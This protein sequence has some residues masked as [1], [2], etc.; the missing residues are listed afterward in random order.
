MPFCH[1]LAR[2]LRFSGS[3][4]QAA[5][6]KS[7]RDGLRP[8]AVPLR[9]YVFLTL[10]FAIFAS[11][12]EGALLLVIRFAFGQV[13]HASPYV[14]WMLP[15]SYMILF[16]VV[17]L[18]FAGIGWIVP[19]RISSIAVASSFGF[20]AAFGP[21]LVMQSQGFHILAIVLLSLGLAATVRRLARRRPPGGPAFSR[22]AVLG[23][24]ALVAII[25]LAQVGLRSI[26]GDSEPTGPARGEVP[27]VLLLVLDTVRAKS[28]GLYGHDEPTTPEIEAFAEKGVV[29]DRGVA[30][31]PW[32]LPSHGS[33][34]TG[35]YPNELS[36]DWD[37]PLDDTYPT[38]AGAMSSGGYATAGFVGNLA[39]VSR[40]FGLNRGFEHYDD[41][42]ISLGQLMVS[43]SAGR[44]IAAI[45][46][47]RELLGFHDLLNRRSAAD[48]NRALLDWLDRPSRR[49][50]F[51]FV[52]YFDA[53]EPYL[54]PPDLAR[55]FGARP[56]ERPV[57]QWITLF[58]GMHGEVRAGWELSEE[59]LANG[60]A[61]YEAA[62]AALD[63]EIGSLLRELER[64]GELD[65]TIVIITSDHGEQHGEHGLLGHV[66]SVYMPL[67][68]VPLVIVHPGSVP[69]GVRV[70][71]EVTLADLPATILDLT[72][73]A[74]GRGPDGK[75]LFPGSSLAAHWKGP[76]DRSL[77]ERAAISELIPGLVLRDWYPVARGTLTSLIDGP[78]HFIESEDGATQ[79]FDTAEDPEE[80]VD[81]AGQTDMQPVL[82]SLRTRLQQLYR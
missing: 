24:W 44:H 45:N 59:Q 69:A 80:L 21:L 76:Q 27:N 81:L 41:F 16:S 13:V 62:I 15:L 7:P 26:Q 20:L 31:A 17:V 19:G 66:N 47:L 48:L 11:A 2:R 72:G 29:F 30:T 35:R 46:W 36:T 12:L 37:D 67:L 73:V 22:F 4:N 58:L 77:P 78:Y 33:I 9:A 42:P 68:H 71:A 38:I 82:D 57:E 1:V 50:F 40:N 75:N 56:T 53:H 43:S 65:R 51:A 70:G 61:S 55:A 14:I 74:G 79:L 6:M 3:N 23:L 39:Y 64:R 49:P 18:L 10:Q 25:A 5:H 52:N 8:E 60:R 63:R 28:L 34:L 32:T 54:P